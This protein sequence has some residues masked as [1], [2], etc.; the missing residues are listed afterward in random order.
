MLAEDVL[1]GELQGSKMSKTQALFLQKRQ[2]PQ[3][4]YNTA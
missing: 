1:H 4:N 2:P 3:A